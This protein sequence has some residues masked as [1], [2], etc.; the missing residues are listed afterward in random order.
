MTITI[1]LAVRDWDYLVPLALGDLR[2]KEFNLE[3]HRLGTLPE[4]LA[5][6]PLYDAGEVSFSRYAQ[7]RARG[8]RPILGI[9]HFLMRAFRQRCIITSK[10]NP[11]TRLGE[12]AGRRIGLT[13]WQDSG[14]TWTRA[15]LR[16]EGVDIEDASW[17]AGRLTATHP[18][19]DRLGGYGRKVASSRSRGTADDGV[20][21]EG[22]LDAVFTP[23]MPPGFFDANSPFRQL[24]A[25]FPAGGDRVF[26]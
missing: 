18:I 13:G 20:A 7:A 16:R 23:F 4:D 10:K 21:R 12:L 24:H 15:L 25:G 1:R 9:P 5:T 3:I 17:F 22:W 19:L 6:D 11:I 14:N 26:Q 8:D 2:P